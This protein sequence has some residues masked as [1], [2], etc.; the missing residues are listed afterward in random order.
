M[1]AKQKEQE[2]KVLEE[3]AR[4]QEQKIKQLELEKQQKMGDTKM[5]ATKKQ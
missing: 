3:K 2:L 1:L 4:Q 5:D